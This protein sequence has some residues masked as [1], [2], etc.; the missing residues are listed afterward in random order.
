[1]RMR[2]LAHLL[3]VT[4]LL[5]GAFGVPGPRDGVAA[6]ASPVPAEYVDLYAALAATLRAADGSIM[7]RWNG[8]KY[9]TIF[10]AEL[11]PANGNIGEPLLRPEAWQAILINLD[12][13]QRLGV[14]SVR[15][16]IKYPIL[17]SV[18][19]RSGEYLG[20]YKRVSQEL[21]KRNLT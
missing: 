16:A 8:Q 1:M 4:A 20:F 15:V 5:G 11:L 3:V 6:P 18:F 12:A 21:K 7:S 9:D 19:P 2:R 13:L 10:S 14:R 17:V